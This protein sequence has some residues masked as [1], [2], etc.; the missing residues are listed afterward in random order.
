VRHKAQ[1]SLLVRAIAKNEENELNPA[2]FVQ[3]FHPQYFKRLVD[4]GLLIRAGRARYNLYHP[5]FRQ[6]LRQQP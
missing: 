4:K 2:P 6:F 3:K 5:L 1:E